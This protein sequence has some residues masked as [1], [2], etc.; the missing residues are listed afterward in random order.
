MGKDLKGKELGKGIRQRK[1]KRYEGRAVINSIEISICKSNLKECKEEF[2][3]AKSQALEDIDIRNQNI[4][5]NQ[6]FEEWFSNYRQPYIKP[7]SIFP[8]RSK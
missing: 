1:D 4:T 2:E 3:K 6:W 7:S 8:M 5:L